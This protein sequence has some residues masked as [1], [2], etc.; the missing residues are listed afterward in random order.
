MPNKRFHKIYLNFN[1]IQCYFI[2]FVLI[3]QSNDNTLEVKFLHG[4]GL[5]C[6]V[7]KLIQY[8]NTDITHYC[9]TFIYL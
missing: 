4:R 6:A 1:Q 7:S 2:D 8:S 3:K 9:L 5:K